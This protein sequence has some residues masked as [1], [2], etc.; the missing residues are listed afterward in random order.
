MVHEEQLGQEVMDRKYHCYWIFHE[1][2]FQSYLR[3]Y[4]FFRYAFA[5]SVQ[6]KSGPT[7]IRVVYSNGKFRLESEARLTTVMPVFDCPI[8]MMEYYRDYTNKVKL[9]RRE[10]IMVDC[11]GV[12]FTKICLTEP[13]LKEVRSL[14]HLA[15]IEINKNKANLNERIER[16]ASSHKQYLAEYPYTVWVCIWENW[17]IQ[18]YA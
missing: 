3:I 16:L 14:Q 4:S 11:F 12:K 7:S 17:R 8:Q 10:V 15:R 9:Q 2:Y 6:T 1:Y 5:L 18:L 13:I